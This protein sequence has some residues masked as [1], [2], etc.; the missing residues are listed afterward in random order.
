MS[1]DAAEPVWSPCP[2]FI[3]TKSYANTL[4]WCL[5]DT[6]ENN[7]LLA[8]QL[9]IMFPA[10]ALGLDVSFIQ[11]HCLPTNQNSHIDFTLESYTL[12][13]HVNYGFILIE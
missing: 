3:Y 8:V 12:M 1:F 10:E 4:L 13:F 7:K 11:F 9:L 2:P 5:K 6:Y